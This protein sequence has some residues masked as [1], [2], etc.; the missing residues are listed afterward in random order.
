VEQLHSHPNSRNQDSCEV[1]GAGCFPSQPFGEARGLRM[2]E[3]A[4]DAE[5][6]KTRKQA[7][8]GGTKNRLAWG[9]YPRQ[10]AHRVVAS[11]MHESLGH[12]HPSLAPAP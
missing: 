10:I 11:Q 1:G 12:G 3:P 2:V 6:E 9:L 5:R 8:Y 4:E 7:F